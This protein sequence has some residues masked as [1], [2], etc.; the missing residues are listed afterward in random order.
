MDST[1]SDTLHGNA[2]LI[3]GANRDVMTGGAGSDTFVFSLI[4]DG[5]AVGGYQDYVM[6]FQH[7]A[8]RIDLSGVDAK[9]ATAGDDTDRPIILSNYDL[10]T[11][12]LCA[13]DF[14]L[15]ARCCWHNEPPLSRR[16]EGAT[17]PE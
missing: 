12:G 17:C 15:Q 7:L 3:G 2:N 1:H 16:T 5:S 10:A 11:R 9:S 8:E 4:T 13:R 6:N 14:I